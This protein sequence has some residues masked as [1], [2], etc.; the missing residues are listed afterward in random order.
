MALSLEQKREIVLHRIMQTEREFYMNELNLKVLTATHAEANMLE[1]T[2]KEIQKCE[3]IINIL[4]A[5]MDLLV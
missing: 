1:F 4:N 5:E 2:R 3:D